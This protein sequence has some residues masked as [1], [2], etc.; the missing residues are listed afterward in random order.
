MAMHK[1]SLILGLWLFTSVLLSAQSKGHYLVEFEA[2]TPS[3][4][5]LIASFTGF[6]AESFLA[7]DVDGN[8]HYLADYKG[9]VAILWFWSIHDQ[10]SID[11]LSTMNLLQVQYLEEVKLLGFASEMTEETKAFTSR[12]G[13][14]FA[15]IPNGDVFGQMA[16]GADLGKPRAFI[17][18][19]FGII[20]YV[21]PASFFNADA[22]EVQSD[23]L[24]AMI[25]ELLF[26]K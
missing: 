13:L 9:K 24:N 20:R 16:Y 3:E 21:L 7:N 26:D 22:I 11:W 23:K 6:P 12:E 25:R 14:V 5:D 10:M 1:M 15:N 18:D 17:I 4:K 8:E 2:F 19:E